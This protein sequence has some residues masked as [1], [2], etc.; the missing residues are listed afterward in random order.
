MSAWAVVYPLEIYV[1]GD[2]MILPIKDTVGGS[3]LEEKMLLLISIPKE[4]GFKSK[5]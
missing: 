2:W 1:A 3:D 5:S 4:M